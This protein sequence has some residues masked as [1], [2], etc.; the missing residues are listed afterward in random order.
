MTDQEI[1]HRHYTTEQF[2]RIFDLLTIGLAFWLALLIYGVP[3]SSVYVLTLTSSIII[4]LIVAEFGGVY[5]VD[6]GNAVKKKM[7]IVFFSWLTTFFVLMALGYLTKT[8]GDVSRVTMGLWFTLTPVLLFLWRFITCRLK[9]LR[10]RNGHFIKSVS[11]V[12]ANKVGGEMASYIDDNQ[13]LGLK[14]SGFF[15]DRVSVPDRIESSLSDKI[16]GSLSDLIQQTKDNQIQVVYIVLPM[17]AEKRIM[18]LIEQLGD[19]TAS[20]HIVPNFFVYNL[21]HSRWHNIG[22][23]NALSIYD[24][25]FYGI[26]S[27]LKKLEDMVIGFIILLLIAIPMLVIALL[28]KL[29]S[30]GP[31]IFHQTR[32]G[33]GGKEVIVRKFR[34]MT[35]CE[36]DDGQIKQAEKGDCRITRL[37]AFLRKTSLDELPQFFNVL[38]G[39]MSIVGPRPHAVAHNELYRDEIDG[40]MLR[41]L[42]KPGITGWAQINGYRGE[43]KEIWMMKKRVEYDL[44]YIRNWSLYWD[45]KIIFLTVFRGF[46]NKNAY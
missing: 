34:T 10:F 32:Y 40:Y 14:F 25:P 38:E 7:S 20:V 43:T 31:V 9:L 3:P 21:I 28:I 16:I 24:T 33:I 27:L 1:H 36:D 30:A 17:S 26:G 8:G 12:G 15:D 19:T 37:G 45:L 44:T 39:S 5:R 6:P 22:S 29:T 41:H 42:V 2:F 35:V 23:F 13:G 46:V 11:I 18:K 4:Y